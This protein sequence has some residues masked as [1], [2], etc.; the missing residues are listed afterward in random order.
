MGGYGMGGYGRYGGM[1]GYGRYGGMGGY[2]GYGMGYGGYGMGGYG[3][4]YY[5]SRYSMWGNSASPMYNYY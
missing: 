1:G 2:G 5:N 4:D 3:G